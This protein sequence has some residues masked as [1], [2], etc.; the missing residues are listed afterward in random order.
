VSWVLFGAV[1]VAGGVYAL[2]RR[3]KERE[4]EEVS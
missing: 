3:T 4:L 1:A 2:R